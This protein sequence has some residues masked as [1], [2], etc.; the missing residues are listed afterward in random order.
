MT[1]NPRPPPTNHAPFGGSLGRVPSRSAKNASATSSTLS[2]STSA[3][4]RETAP[5]TGRSSTISQR[6]SWSS[7]RLP[8]A[9][10][11]S[12]AAV[13]IVRNR[14]NCS[15]EASAPTSAPKS[16]IAAAACQRVARAANGRSGR[17]AVPTPQRGR[18]A[19]LRTRRTTPRNRDRC[20]P[21]LLS[22]PQD[23]SDA[24]SS[25]GCEPF[26]TS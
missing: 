13:A 20:T 15:A 6:R 26:N 2:T 16:V 22:G 24:P 25:S 18:R 17:F 19:T 10:A 11:S 12:R 21:P 23:H 4:V 3:P 8:R 9:R 5:A 7:E 14:I 1:S